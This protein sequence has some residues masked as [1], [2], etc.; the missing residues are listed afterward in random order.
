MENVFLLS[1]ALALFK[2]FHNLWTI[3][4]YIYIQTR[5]TDNETKVCWINRDTPL[6][7]HQSQLNVLQIQSKKTIPTAFNKSH[8]ESNGPT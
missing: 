2:T 6:S 5:C 1:G 4:I 7:E 3:K 8:R